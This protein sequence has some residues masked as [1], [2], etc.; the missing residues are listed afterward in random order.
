[1]ACLIDMVVERLSHP[2][3]PR[4]NQRLANAGSS[5]R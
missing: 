4:A 2:E 5:A 3:G 1:M